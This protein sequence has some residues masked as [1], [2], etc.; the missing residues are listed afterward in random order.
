MLATTAAYPPSTSTLSL[1]D[2][3]AACTRPNPKSSTII[4]RLV[5]RFNTW[6][7]AKKRGPTRASS[8]G[9]YQQQQLQRLRKK[10][11]ITLWHRLQASVC[12]GC[13][14]RL[15]AHAF[16]NENFAAC[17]ACSKRFFSEKNRPLKVDENILVQEGVEEAAPPIDKD[18]IVDVEAGDS[19]QEKRLPVPSFRP[20]STFEGAFERKE[21]LLDDRLLLLKHAKYEAAE[22]KSR[23]LRPTVLAS[24]LQPEWVQRR[25]ATKSA[26]HNSSGSQRRRRRASK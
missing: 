1:L 12:A 25:A 11:R 10:L 7:F 16:F 18:I 2:T 15:F 19:L 26:A 8:D 14:R 24:L 4:G 6:L 3:P 23:L 13:R 17:T 21:P 5:D 20:A 22:R 9:L